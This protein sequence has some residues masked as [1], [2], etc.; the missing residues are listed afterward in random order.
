MM[1]KKTSFLW[2]SML[3]QVFFYSSSSAQSW[4][5]QPSASFIQSP[6][7][8]ITDLVFYNQTI[9]SVQ[10]AITKSRQLYP[11]NLIRITMSGQYTF[12][13]SALKLGSQML[14]FLNNATLQAQA[15][16]NFSSIF[17][18]TNSQYITISGTGTA[19]INGGNQS[20]IGINVSNSG[21]VHVDGISF[22]DC[23]NGA[24]LYQGKGDNVFAD[25][26]SVTRCSISNCDAFGIQFTNATHFVCTDNTI[27]NC[28]TGIKI[29]GNSS[30]V[31][32]NTIKTCNTGIA[33]YAQYES[34]VYNKVDS[35]DTAIVL[36]S[37][38]LETLVANNSLLKN[39]VGINA[40]G[41]K[42]RIYNNTSQNTIPIT[43]AGTGNQLFC[44]NGIGFIAGNNS[45]CTYFNPPLIGNQ[46][47]NRIKQGKT[48]YDI[49]ITDTTLMAIRNLVDSAHA[50]KP[51]AVIVIHLNGNFKTTSA[52][53]SLLILDNECYLL[54]GSITCNDTC[55][56]VLYCKGNILSSF[57]GGTINGNYLGGKNALIYITGNGSLVLDSIQ[58]RNSSDEGI[59]KR[60]SFGATYLR[61]CTIK[62]SLSRNVWFLGSARLF[63]FENTSNNAYYDGYDF[64]AFTSYGVL[65]NNIGMGNKRHGVFIEEG[66]QN[67]LVMGNSFANNLSGISFYNLAVNNTNTAKN[68]VAY[69]ICNA[70]QRGMNINASSP[71]KATIDNTLFNN[72]C[73]NNTDVGMGGYY[74]GAN[75]YG[76]Y[77][78]FPH[79][80]NN[81]NGAFF[82]NINYSANYFW[83]MLPNAALL[84]LKSI[85]LSLQEQ[86]NQVQLN[87]SSPIINSLHHFEIDYSV[88]GNLFTTKATVFPKLLANHAQ[89]YQY[90][91]SNS[92]N[93]PSFYRIKMV[94]NDGAITYS[95]LVSTKSNN[96]LSFQIINPQKG[97]LIINTHF[98]EGIKTPSFYVYDVSGRLI[99]SKQVL[100][101]G[102]YTETI[103][104]AHL[105][106]GAYIIKVQSGAQS[107]T[108]QVFIN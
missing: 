87:W 31:A 65:V 64:D 22:Q 5:T 27:Q 23:K 44:N 97:L 78:A 108:Q 21:K 2:V 15:G 71:S 35:C 6:T 53:D 106:S 70:N 105:L 86:E 61:G 99:A 47:N 50:A 68:L 42:A 60:S 79:F 92:S 81:T 80:K 32:N 83:N 24:V 62:N 58:I 100:D 3:L 12:T 96:A 1:M 16:A 102:I 11:N 77:T 7:E 98:K 56:T 73:T 107:I 67:H 103:Q 39:T 74:S 26:G 4:F 54:N 94:E 9:D 84:P 57:S 75:A 30:A 10:K 101:L 33:S 8:A 13:N 20:I 51:T 48:R 19:V 14:L 59:T 95:N 85:H 104:F 25:A 34:I 52:T 40:N 29:D 46:H 17:E 43:G 49:T 90:L 41:T 63:A 88:D 45:G 28:L 91:L 66:A 93:N 18:V 55:S 76:N 82:P 36:S 89:P 38:S 72:A 37:I 69:N